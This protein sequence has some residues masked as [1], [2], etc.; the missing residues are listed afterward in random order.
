[1]KARSSRQNGLFSRYRALAARIAAPFATLL[2]KARAG[3]MAVAGKGLR[4]I[5]VFS[6][7]G[8]CLAAGLGLALFM[9]PLGKPQGA[10]GEKQEPSFGILMP[11]QDQGEPD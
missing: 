3:L 7:L 4:R 6:L 11:I 5:I 9:T 8:A 1:M 10:P 2:A